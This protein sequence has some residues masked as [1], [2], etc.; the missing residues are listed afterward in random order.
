MQELHEKLLI[1]EMKVKKVEF[2]NKRLE[3]RLSTTQQEKETIFNELDKLKETN[4]ELKS[5]QSLNEN[6]SI[7]KSSFSNESLSQLNS[8]I[9]SEIDLLNVPLEL[10]F[11][12]ST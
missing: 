8:N 10:K 9:F 3:E 2:E 12:E 11:V 7:D 6:T 1:E 5:M 4:E